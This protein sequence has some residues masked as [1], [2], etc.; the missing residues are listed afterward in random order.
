LKLAVEGHTDSVGGD[1]ANQKL[2]E[3]RA[4]AVRK[5]LVEEGLADASVSSQG[6]WQDVPGRRQRHGRLG[7][8]KNRRVEIVVSG[9]VIGEKIG[10]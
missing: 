3:Q 10:T 4:D 8:R 7:D 2:S 5:Y 1:E 6:L 9:E